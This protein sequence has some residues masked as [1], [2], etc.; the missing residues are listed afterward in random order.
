MKILFR[1]RYLAFLCLI[2]LFAS[3]YS[4]QKPD[5]I[6]L[7]NVTI[8]DMRGGPPQKDM[9]VLIVGNRIDKIDQVDRIKLPK[10]A[11]VLDAS[12][13]YLI[14]GLWDMHVHLCYYSEAAFPLLIK[15]GITGV[16]DMGGDLE[17]IDQWQKEIDERERIGPRIIRSG[18]VV[19]GP[20]P[21]VQFRLTV[22][23]TTEVQK[24]V[25]QLK[26][27]GVDFIKIHNKVPP[28]AYFVL[29]EEA[30]K[31]GI[32]F[33]GHIPYGVSATEASAAGQKSIEHTEVLLEAAIYQKENSAKSIMDALDRIK[34]E[35][36]IELFKIFVKNDTWYIP[37]LVGYRSIVAAA[38]NEE[39]RAGREMLLQEFIN[40]VG[41]MHGAG[42]NIMAGTDFNDKEF[43]IRPGYDLHD[44]L[45]FFVEAGLTPLEALQTATLKP[46]EFL[47]KLSS[48]G[49]VEEGKIA[50]LIL[51]EKNPL[52]DI[53]NVRKI[54]AV[55]LHGKL[56]PLADL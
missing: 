16:R 21:D 50:D 12:G 56:I 39:S 47:G 31:L 28:D 25:A 11:S 30:N 8:I 46:A 45:S 1:W 9:A 7:M 22:T 17:Q 42:V 13:K 29:A 44:E 35:K 2:A 54:Q 5:S 20:K 55:I 52:D 19:D 15:N 18:L 4:E 37:T 53:D 26:Q 41:T 14:P 43:G 38:E 48:Y 40:I 36:A 24:A 3:C 27:S 33:V 34:G 49:T 6:A 23:N 32:S 51:L 10:D